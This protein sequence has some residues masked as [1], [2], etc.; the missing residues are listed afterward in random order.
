M[1][2][3]SLIITILLTAILT[4]HSSKP[5]EYE[6]PNILW[7]TS[8]DNNIHWVGCYGNPNAETPNIDALAEEGFQYM[9]CYANA[10]VCASQRS[11]WITG[12][13]SLSMGT[14]PMRSRNPIPHDVIRYYPDFL[15]DAGYY[16]SNGA[17]T[18]YNIGGRDDKE[19]WDNMDIK[20]RG[21][22]VVDW[23]SLKQNQPFFKVINFFDSHESRSHG[24][25]ENTLHVPEKTSLHAYHPDIPVIRKNYAKYHDAVKRMDNQIGNALKKLEELGLSENTIV[26]YNSDHGGVMP[27]SKRFLFP[28]GIHCPLIVRIPEKYKDLYPADKPGS[29][30]DRIVSF[31]DMPKTWLSLAEADIP[32]YMQ[33]TIFLGDRMEKEEEYHFAFRGRMDERN[34]NARAVYDK[35]FVYIRNYMPYVPW[36]QHLNTMWKIKTSIAWEEYVKTGKASIEQS[37]FLYPKLYT[38]EFYSLNEDWDNTNNLIDNPAYADKIS[39]MREALQSW[40]LEIFDAGLLPESEMIK[41]AEEH[42]TTIYE[43]VRDPGIYDLPA[44]LDAADLAMQEDPNNIDLLRSMLDNDDSGIRYWAMVGC[45]LLNDNIGTKKVMNDASHE[46]RA[47]AAWTLLRTGNRSDGINILEDMLTSDSYASLK[48][49]N[50]IDWM[51]EDGKE[52]MPAV[53]KLDLSKGNKNYD[54]RMKNYLEIK[55]ES[56]TGPA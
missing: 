53:R 2:R 35:E 47:M 26:I 6:R 4:L 49:L 48:I 16:I 55:F 3:S 5:E 8:E 46:V 24:N 18:D 15:K 14:H 40:Q 42:N 36:L 17:K 25:V 31:I 43:M 27:R 23:E 54:E 28:S 38:E 12:I 20:S 29:T 33:G 22:S 52:L 7:L 37:K 34:E 1:L 56:S 10:P 9:H 50:I 39:S 44:L 13:Y 41:R 21:Q 11:T 51:G 32:D 45:F 30:V 19:C